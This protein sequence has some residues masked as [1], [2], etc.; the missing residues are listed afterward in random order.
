MGIP[1]ESPKQ[2]DSTKEMRIKAQEVKFVSG[3]F[4]ND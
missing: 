2:S 3:S 1:M 4:C